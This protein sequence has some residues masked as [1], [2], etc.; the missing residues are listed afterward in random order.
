MSARRSGGK[1]PESPVRDSECTRCEWVLSGKV[2][3]PVNEHSPTCPFRD[4]DRDPEP[5]D[6]EEQSGGR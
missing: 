5:V 3:E 4:T 6:V 2:G 1:V